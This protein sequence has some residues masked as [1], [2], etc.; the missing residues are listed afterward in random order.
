LVISH[1]GET[2]HGAE[3]VALGAGP[4]LYLLGSVAFK[5]RVFGEYWRKRAVALVLVAVATAVGSTLAALATWTIM[6]AILAGL[7]IAEAL[8]FRAEG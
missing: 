2:L 4:A 6:L 3:L 7:A 8:E 1:P 5:I